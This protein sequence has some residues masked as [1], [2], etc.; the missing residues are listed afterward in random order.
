ML[1]LFLSQIN[2]YCS[3]TIYFIFFLSFE[4]NIAKLRLARF[5]VCLAEFLLYSNPRDTEVSLAC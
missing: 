3:F 2:L 4:R 5:V 1:H